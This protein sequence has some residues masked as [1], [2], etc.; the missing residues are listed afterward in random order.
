METQDNITTKNYYITK[1]EYIILQDA[2]KSGPWPSGYRTAQDHI[3]YNI[4]RG[5]DAKRGFREKVKN[6][7]GGH[8][9]WA[10]RS[11]LY[12]LQL[13]LQYGRYPKTFCGIELPVDFKDKVAVAIALE[14]PKTYPTGPLPAK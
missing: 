5:K 3:V 9:A 8:P 1:E 10:Y 7:Q 11:P 2:W 13:R 14:Y 12:R 4:L 6:I